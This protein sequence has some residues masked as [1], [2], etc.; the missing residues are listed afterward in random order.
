MRALTITKF[1]NPDVLK[2]LELPDPTPGDGELRIKVARAG[3]NF[4]EISARVGLYPDAPPPP[5]CA[6]YEV[7]G[8]VDAIG[9][10]VT[11]WQTGERVLGMCKF[12]GHASHAVM[13]AEQAQRLPASMSFDEG[14][15]LPVNY[16]TAFHMM[17]RV[18]NLQPG[19]KLLIHMAAG[20]VGLAVLQLA[21][22]V[23]GVE[24]FGTASASKHAL[25]KEMG[26]QHPIDYHSV[27]YAD[28]IRRI[29]N[30]RGVDMVLDALGGADWEKGYQ[31]LAPAGHLVAFGWANMVS[32]SKR[33]VFHVV[34]EFFGMKKYA[35]MKLMDHNKT[36]SGV[37]L[38]HLWGEVPMMTGHLKKLIALSEKGVVKPRVD[39]V[40]KL[41]DGPAAHQYVQDRKNVGKVVFDCL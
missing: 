39:K 18:G 2:V 20:G 28:E 10:G 30:G 16:L 36:V 26:V 14:A 19:Q 21:K 6:G 34:K 23:E 4:A 15:A 9:P 25:L 11:G 13:R 3:L 33:N 17:F 41:V 5:F 22:L 7:A 40:F 31:L 12:G 8:T 32:G 37:N 38:G 24:I 27:D 1:G 29:T 35:P